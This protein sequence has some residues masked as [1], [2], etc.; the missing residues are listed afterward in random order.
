MLVYKLVF[1]EP[2]QSRSAPAPP[3]WEPYK[4]SPYGRG[5]TE[6]DGEGFTDKS[7]L[8]IQIDVCRILFVPLSSQGG[9]P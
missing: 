3:E 4:A 1:I 6:G 9:G 2:S 5:V 7:K 8:E